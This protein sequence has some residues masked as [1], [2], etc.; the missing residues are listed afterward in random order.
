M[1]EEKGHMYKSFQG[2]QPTY[3]PVNAYW[4]LILGFWH[5]RNTHLRCLS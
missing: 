2:V 1:I 3:Q 5:F 4:A